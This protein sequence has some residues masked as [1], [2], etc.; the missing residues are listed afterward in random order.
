MARWLFNYGS[1]CRRYQLTGW[2]RNIPLSLSVS[3]CFILDDRALVLQPP[4][5]SQLPL[6]ITSPSQFGI[7]AKFPGR[8]INMP[9]EQQIREVSLVVLNCSWQKNHKDLGSNSKVTSVRY[10]ARMRRCGY[11][12]LPLPAR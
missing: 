11:R 6:A 7:R 5:T 2:E 9:H 8:N 4:V 12:T 1:S 10:E 3:V